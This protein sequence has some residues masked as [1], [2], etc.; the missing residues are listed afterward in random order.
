MSEFGTVTFSGKSGARYAFTAYPL[1]ALFPRGV[2]GMYVV[3][4]RT[5]GKPRKGF[6]HKRLCT[7]QSDDLCQL[8]TGDERSFSAQGTNCL[9]V[10]TEKDKGARRTIE[11]D[12]AQEPRAGRA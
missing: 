10:H 12:L 6:L 4:Q 3:T 9:C 11:Q 2:G 7:G 1:A 8:L 5:Q